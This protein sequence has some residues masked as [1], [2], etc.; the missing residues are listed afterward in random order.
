MFPFLRKT[1]AK[2]PEP[3][4]WA[5]FEANEAMLFDFERD[6]DP[7]FDR[8]AAALKKISTDLAFEFGPKEPDGR[9]ELVISAGGMK[10]AF[11]AVEKLVAAAPPLARWRFT[12]FRPRRAQLMTLE[13]GG[14]KVEPKDVDCCFMTGGP[15]L[16]IALFFHGYTEARRNEF[17]QVG[18]LMLDEALGEYDV[19]MKVGPIRFVAFEEA[20]NAVRFPLTELTARFDARHAERLQ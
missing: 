2:P 15:L 14:L 13:F 1:P 6:R 10:S 4:F 12:A 19:A 11:P 9:R 8:L 16:G 18:F 20:P 7:V 17:G 5:W 3:T